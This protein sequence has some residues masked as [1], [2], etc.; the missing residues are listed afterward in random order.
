MA[1]TLYL[2][3]TPIG[4][5]E[6]I[7][8]RAINTLKQVDII[9]AEDTRHTLNLLNHFNIKTSMTSY[10]EHNKITKGQKLIKYLL[11]NKNIALVTDAGTPAISDPGEDLVKLALENNINITSIPGAS[12]LINAL[13]ISGMS[14]RR[15]V[16]EG[17]MPSDKKEKKKVLDRLVKETRTIIIYEAPHRLKT[18]LDELYITLGNRNIALVKELT[19][20]Y[21]QVNRTDLEQSIL[22]YQTNESKGEFVIIIEGANEQDLKDENITKWQ[23]IP[24][25]EHMKI[26]I[27]KNMSKKEA[28]KQVAKDRGITKR[29]VYYNLTLCSKKSPY[30]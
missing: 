5:L 25:E 13:I 4:N 7:S 16:F 10:H 18:T 15:F 14:T 8:I 19:K 2:C 1:G 6:D 30:F 12:A 24:L 21:E 11:D 17:F 20:K 28:M 22:Y 26:Y 23:S 27:D 9:A 29:E 3:A